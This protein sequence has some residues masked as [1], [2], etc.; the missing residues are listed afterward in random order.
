KINA[1]VILA[2]KR[3]LNK[4]QTE[5]IENFTNCVHNALPSIERE[6][7]KNILIVATRDWEIDKV[8]PL[9]DFNFMHVNDRIKEFDNIYSFFMT[10]LQNI[11]VEQLDYETIDFLR[12]AVLTCYRDFLGSEGYVVDYYSFN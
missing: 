11:L 1:L 9:N 6:T 3:I 7:L 2:R 10:R 12:K 8:L 5:I 4:V